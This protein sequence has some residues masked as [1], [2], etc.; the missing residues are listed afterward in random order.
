MTCMMFNADMLTD[1]TQAIGAVRT[2][3]AESTR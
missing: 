2:V 1:V 3:G